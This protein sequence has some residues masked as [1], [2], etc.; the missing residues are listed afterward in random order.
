MHGVSCKQVAPLRYE[1]DLVTRANSEGTPVS[2]DSNAMS[3][4][5]YRST[6]NL[7]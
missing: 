7:S 6:L 1:F 2:F 4:T 5:T 3:L